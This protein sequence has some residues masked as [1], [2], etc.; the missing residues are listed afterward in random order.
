MAEQAEDR[1]PETR[2]ALVTVAQRLAQ[3]GLQRRRR[4]LRPGLQIHV[5]LAVRRREQLS[6]AGAEIRACSG[7]VS[8]ARRRW[9]CLSRGREQR[10]NCCSR[11]RRRQQAV[12]Q[13]AA[14]VWAQP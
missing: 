1:A 4:L 11:R 12:A 7:H 2:L 6:P 5:M 13:R 3:D 14:F 9:K 10:A 8:P